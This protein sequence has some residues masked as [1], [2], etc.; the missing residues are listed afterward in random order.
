MREDIVTSLDIVTRN[1][2]NY[3][4]SEN[5]P[6][7]ILSDVNT[8]IKSTKSDITIDEPAVWI[9]QHPTIME[10]EK[11]INF[12]GLQRLQTTF[13]FICV[14]YDEDLETAEDKGI[15]LATRVGKCILKNF[16]KVKDKETD[17]IHI[18]D[19]VS[20][21]ALYPVGEVSVEGKATRIP[22]TSIVMKFTYQVNWKKCR[23]PNS[24]GE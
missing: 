13:E 10:D 20:L 7:G 22:A 6:E 17:P 21:V 5:V 14:E 4:T 16:N 8:I 3:V 12:G 15:N 9:S 11:A 1:V 19:N 24:I 2:K 23:I 18:F